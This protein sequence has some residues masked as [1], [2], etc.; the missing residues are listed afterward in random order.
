MNIKTAAAD[1]AVLNVKSWVENGRFKLSG[2]KADVRRV[3]ALQG[4]DMV[5]DGST[6]WVVRNDKSFVGM[7]VVGEINHNFAYFYTTQ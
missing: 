6:T 7:L 4:L 1:A 3:I 5:R 2:T